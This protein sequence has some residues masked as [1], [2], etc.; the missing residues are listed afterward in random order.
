MFVAPIT[1]FGQS[2][3]TGTIAGIVRD[4]TG[5]VLPGVTVEASSPAL[6]EKMRA[7]VSDD[8]GN[9]K[10]IDLRPGTYTVTFSLAGFN[11]VERVGVEVNTGL[12]V[13][14]NVDLRV[15]TQE[16]T[17]TVT[18]A[19]PVV[20]VQNVNTQAVLT[21]DVIDNLPTNR[22]L[23]GFA[24]MIVG[25]LNPT[26]TSQDVGGSQTDASNSAFG[27]HGNR[28]ADLKL[29]QDGMNYNNFTSST[30]SGDGRFNY[31]N[32]AAVQEV[33]LQTSGMSAESETGGVQL[34]VVPKEGGNQFR[35]YFAGGATGPSLQ[36]SNIDD[37]LRARNV[38]V[39]PDSTA[40]DFNTGFGGPIM[41]DRLWFYAANRFGG[42][43]QTMVSNFFNK[44]QGVFVGV[45]TSG[46]TLYAADQSRPAQLE[47]FQRDYSGRVT[48]QVAAK[49]KVNV[50]H[51]F[52]DNCSCWSGVDGLVA[53][54]AAYKF[55]FRPNTLTQATWSYPATHRLL[56]EG[57]VTVVRN[58]IQFDPKVTE[59]SPEAI[60]ILERSIGYRYNARLAGLTVTDYTFGDGHIS[61]QTNGRL[62]GAFVTGSHAVKVGMQ[63]M[64]GKNQT[65]AQHNQAID[66]TFN[67]GIPESLRIWAS[68]LLLRTEI[69]P[70]LAVFAQDQWTLRRLT[71]NLGLRI[72]HLHAKVPAQTSAAGR[73]VPER[74]FDSVD[75]VPN[76]NDA[77]A[78]LGAAYDVFGN[79]RTAIKG[80]LGRYVLAQAVTLANAV[81]PAGAMV[82]SAA[83]SWSDN[84]NF[85]PDCDLLNFAA[86][87]RD[88]DLCGPMTPVDF[89]QLRART[90]T[91]DPGILEGWGVRPYNWQGSVSFQHQ[92]VDRVAVNVGYFRTWYGNFTVTD[93]R[94]IT[95]ADFDPYCVTAPVDARLGS[96]SG[97]QICGL[98]DLSV[99]GSRAGTDNFVTKA[100]NFGK[101]TE[102]YNG[103]DVTMNARFGERGLLQGGFSTGRTT[104]EDCAIIDSPSP[105]RLVDGSRPI[106][107]PTASMV[108]P[109][110]FCAYELPFSAQTQ[111]K[112]SG[113]YPLPWWGIQMSGTFQNLP[114]VNI[115]AIRTFTAQETTLGRNF[116]ANVP[117]TISLFE[118]NQLLDD[119]LTQ[120]DFRATKLFRIGK[121]RF[122]GNFDVYNIFNA[123]TVLAVN[124]TY[125]SSGV[126]AWQNPTTVLAGRLFKIGGQVE[127]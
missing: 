44:N 73:F 8:S 102:V 39:A 43:K 112:F 25:A 59:S 114:G 81:N 95:P 104:F 1:A 3:T 113:V 4:S 101:R 46:V 20:D 82:P 37:D 7:A 91:Y 41:R 18:G 75:N 28:S 99:A 69:G 90:T 127:F 68:P 60:S 54:E 98:Y 38:R 67:R 74:S 30:G 64:M 33:V 105:I 10:V 2:A 126:N 53:P 103:V 61:N 119:R 48:W 21:R 50:S 56:F 5:A 17:I 120:V 45:P 93:N 24:T 96:T 109:Q 29:L 80:S 16:E 34:N 116:S 15:G 92:L 52:Q 22:N 27:I 78:R 88:G 100:E 23:H 11:R 63:L 110:Q 65:Y 36:Q 70:Q 123:N 79:G 66:Y 94:R 106:T 111:F 107:P 76:W 86:N 71:L 97:S 125:A 40:Y 47:K 26:R 62:S 122:Q 83:R 84:G 89:G 121:W 72:D 108:S 42:N 51:A 31:I 19:A 55:N 115:A 118:P 87:G 85:V 58:G 35:F 117:T 124:S 6:I 14:V 12:T 9:Y 32:Q 57:G 49:H 13:T 77:N